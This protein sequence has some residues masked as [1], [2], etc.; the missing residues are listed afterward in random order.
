M[1]GRPS[2]RGAKQDPVPDRLPAALLSLASLHLALLREYWHLLC[3]MEQVCVRVCI[4]TESQIIT[5]LCIKR[6]K[7]NPKPLN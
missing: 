4:Y 1:E 7:K 6:A 2:G 5:R 3:F